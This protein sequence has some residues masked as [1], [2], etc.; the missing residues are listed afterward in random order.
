MN[1][2][3][4]NSSADWGFQTPNGKHS[5]N[6]QEGMGK[7]QSGLPECAARQFGAEFDII[8]S[9]KV[10]ATPPGW[11]ERFWRDDSGGI[12]LLNLRLLSLTPPASRKRIPATAG[13]AGCG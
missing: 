2:L 4:S 9:F 1:I 6:T 13:L 7:I 3:N 12:A 10:S 8:F 5:Q 11:K